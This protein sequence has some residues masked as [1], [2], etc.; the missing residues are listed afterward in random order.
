MDA[1]SEI[2][3]AI[4]SY[5]EQAVSLSH[6]IHQHPELRF[7]ERF[8]CDLL[9]GAVR[10]LGLEVETEIGGLGTSFRAEFGGAGATI[11]ILA[12]YDAL[13]NGHSCGHNRL[14]EQLCRLPRDWRR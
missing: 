5:R 4:D 14:L 9:T 2:C 8:A 3:Q 13:P 11:A 7:Q 1:Y 12:E 6:Q 10:D